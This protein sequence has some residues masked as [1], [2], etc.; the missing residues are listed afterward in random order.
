VEDLEERTVLT[1]FAH[2]AALQPDGKLVV[3]GRA[4]N[5]FALVRYNPDG[6][7]DDKFGTGGRVTT[8]HAN[9]TSEIYG[10]P[11]QDD[12]KIVA[13]GFSFGSGSG[14]TFTLV[15]YN[16][17]GSLDETFGAA[18]VVYTGFG[19]QSASGA[20]ALALDPAGRIVVGG[21]V[22]VSVFV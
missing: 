6:S 14:Q 20:Y 9:G 11:V 22:A 21:V 15:R 13:A 5:D 17:D 3:A 19:P 12:G 1:A 18:G 7:L 10:V 16:P 2:A 8:P 4:F